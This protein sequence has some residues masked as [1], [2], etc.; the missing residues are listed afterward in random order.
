MKTLK[1]KIN[2]GEKTCYSAKDKT[3]KY[4]IGEYVITK[5]G[6][7]QVQEFLGFQ[8]EGEVYKV[9]T[10]YVISSNTIPDNL[11][12][13]MTKDYAPTF[14]HTPTNCWI[15]IGLQ[16]LKMFNKLGR[17]KIVKAF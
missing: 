9:V 13:N 1:L 4:K 15:A 6:R 2:C 10:E 3:M 16:R 8:D 7:A 5:Y 14:N 17:V 11:F 12:A